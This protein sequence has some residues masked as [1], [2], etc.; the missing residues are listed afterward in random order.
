MITKED[1]DKIANHCG[2]EAHEEEI[3]NAILHIVSCPDC[4]KK[5]YERLEDAKKEIPMLQF[6]NFETLTLDMPMFGKIEIG[7]IIKKVIK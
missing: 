5:L 4:R 2:C 7:N 1:T 6:F 3:S